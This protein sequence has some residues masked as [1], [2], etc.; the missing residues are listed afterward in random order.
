MV[1]CRDSRGGETRIACDLFRSA[2]Q[3][4]SKVIEFQRAGTLSQSRFRRGTVLSLCSAKGGETEHETPVVDGRSLRIG[5][6]HFGAGVRAGG[7]RP[8]Q[9]LLCD[10][11]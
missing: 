4:V 2:K 6:P 10:L 11:P 9:N 7:R 3:L 5:G 1:W 8:L